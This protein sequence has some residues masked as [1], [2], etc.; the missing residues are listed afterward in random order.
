MVSNKMEAGVGAVADT[1]GTQK[2]KIHGAAGE[3]LETMTFARSRFCE[4]ERLALGCSAQ[5]AGLQI[6]FQIT[7]FLRET[8]TVKSARAPDS[9]CFLSLDR[10]PV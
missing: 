5:R 9:Y 10:H 1:T 8:W 4:M 6:L 2:E 3:R 7:V